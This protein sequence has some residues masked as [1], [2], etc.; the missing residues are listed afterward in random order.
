[1]LAAAGPAFAE[2]PPTTPPPGTAPASGS[3][4]AIRAPAQSTAAPS[5]A[6]RL[7][8]DWLKAVYE[9]VAVSVVRIQTEVGTGSGF[10]F[11]SRR[12][13]ATA[14]HVVDDADTIIVGMSDGRR[15]EGRVVAY[16][17]ENDLALIELQADVPD[18][19]LLEAYQG[20][21]DVGEPVAIIGHPFSDLTHTSK[22]LRGLLNWSLS[23]GVVGAV[24]ESWL[25]TDAAINPGNSGGPMV[26]ARG[27]LLGVVSAKLTDAQGIGLAARGDRLTELIGR[28]GWSGPPRQAWKLDKVELGF[29][30]H[31]AADGANTINGF[32]LGGGAILQKRYPIRLRASYLAGDID[33]ATPTILT[34]HLERFAT[35]LTFGYAVSL[36][37]RIEFSPE[38]GA[39]LFYDHKGNAGLEVDSRCTDL[40]CTVQGRVVRSNEGALR[41][42]P[43]AGIT[44]EGGFFRVS[45]AFQLDLQHLVDG[46]HR[47]LVGVGF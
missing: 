31:I 37:E 11:Y 10:F 17:R 28:I 7:E 9:Q 12:H 20:P 42:L 32:S 38:F 6:Q 24:S 39:A 18:A 43:Q 27:Q 2:P 34:T 36:T 15:L 47:V 3:E 22:R 13:V 40:P 25:Q 16:S 30:L 35:E 44:L 45:Y 33:G 8:R 21:I 26:N 5:D 23:Q 29:V 14:L 19:R 41:F 1:M 46:N 4:S